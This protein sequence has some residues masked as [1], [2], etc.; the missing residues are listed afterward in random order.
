M[1]EELREWNTGVRG[2]VEGSDLASYA[3]RLREYFVLERSDGI[4]QVRMHTGGEPAVFSL[5]MHNAWCQLWH[6]VGNDP[7]NEVVILTGTG[8]QWIAGVDAESFQTP[9]RD[10]PGDVVYEHGY[11]DGIKLLESLVFGVDVPTIGVLNGPGIRKEAALLCDITLC[12]ETTTIADGNFAAGQ[13]PGDGMHL[14]L[15][16]LLGAKRAAYY[17]YTSEPIDAATARDLGLV[18]E[19][20]PMDRLLPRAWDI[21][22]SIMAKPRASRRLAHAIVQRPWKRC[23]SED[24]GFGLAHQLLSGRMT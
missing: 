6:E 23:L 9:L 10:W 13:A 17:L 19:I 4:L 8:D 22:A 11:H 16:E 2:L 1:S 12:S 14:V 15:Q 7:G 21:A 18:N 20:L 3:K 24:Q 5:G